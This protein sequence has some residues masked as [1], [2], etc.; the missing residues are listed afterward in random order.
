LVEASERALAFLEKNEILL[1]GGV[2]AN[3]RLQEMLRLVAKE[4]NVKFLVVPLEY[5]GDC[6]AQIAWTGILAYKA[7]VKIPVEKSQVKPKWRLD[8]V[9]IPWRT[10]ENIKASQPRYSA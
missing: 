10:W 6:G 1:T 2:A 8:N 9:P 5:S 7:G 3:R 4:H